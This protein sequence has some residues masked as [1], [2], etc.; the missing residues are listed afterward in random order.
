MI[1]TKNKQLNIKDLLFAEN[2][3]DKKFDPRRDI[4]EED[5][6]NIERTLVESDPI[7]GSD[8]DTYRF[9]RLATM[10]KLIKP[11]KFVTLGSGI[12][13]KN[14]IRMKIK[15]FH[16]RGERGHFADLLFS[17]N[18]V[19]PFFKGGDV[20]DKYLIDQIKDIKGI[21]A[22]KKAIN[23][24]A[25][26]LHMLSRIKLNSPKKEL[27]LPNQNEF[28]AKIKDLIEY[29]RE[30]NYHISGTAA[31][32]KIVFPNR[33]NELNI[34]T[35]DWK[36]MKDDLSFQRVRGD[37]YE[38]LELA[39]DMAILSADEIKFDEVGARLI[40]SDKE[41]QFEGKFTLKMPEVRKF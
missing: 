5:W 38:F 36:K 39:T 4:A 34:D 19:N 3:T 25:G 12:V 40:F 2:R 9:Y 22:D 15:D 20:P 28:V 1:E 7:T 27:N 23:L 41:M 31:D 17:A 35:A 24:G 33:I 10:K 32:F 11:E 21:V 13:Y 29:E 26:V 6:E 14:K 37:W 18:Y 30:S 8:S 16:E